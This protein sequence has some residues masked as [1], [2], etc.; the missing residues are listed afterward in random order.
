[1]L[2]RS[3]QLELENRCLDL[4]RS[5]DRQRRELGDACREL[6][7]RFRWVETVVS[8]A[9]SSGPLLMGAAGLAGVFL[10]RGRKGGGLISWVSRVQIGVKVF[11]IARQLLRERR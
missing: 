10:G 3:K 5:G 11:R 2:G 1:M 7:H 6:K 8:A 9:K 4:V